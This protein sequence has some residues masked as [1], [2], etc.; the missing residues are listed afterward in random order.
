MSIKLHKSFAVHPGPWLRRNIV[1]PY[2][3]TQADAAKGLGVTRVALSNVLNGKAALSPEMAI[4]FE[5]GFGVNAATVLRM[6]A[7]YDLAQAT[8]KAK[9]IKVKRIPEPA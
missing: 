2:K 9:S 3:L 8:E 1:E 5:K 4:R 7:A 6:Q